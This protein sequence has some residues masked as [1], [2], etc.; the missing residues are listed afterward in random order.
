M[1]SSDSHLATG[2]GWLD[3]QHLDCF[4]YSYSSVIRSVCS[5]FLEAICSHFLEAVLRIGAAVVMATLWSSASYSLAPGGGVRLYTLSEY[6]LEPLRRNYRSVTMLSHDIIIICSPLA[7]VL[8]FRMLSLLGLNL[9][10]G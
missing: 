10:F 9:F 4:R 1:V 6:C 2:H 7:A 8:C 3:Q 5:H